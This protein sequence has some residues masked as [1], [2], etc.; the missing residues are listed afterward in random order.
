MTSVDY[1]VV[2]DTVSVVVLVAMV[3]VMLGVC[4]GDCGSV[5]CGG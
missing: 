3:L 5:G 4:F 1:L 2:L